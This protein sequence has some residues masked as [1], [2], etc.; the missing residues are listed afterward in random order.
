MKKNLV[1]SIA[2]FTSFIIF[3]ILV[4]NV[5]LKPIGPN[6]SVVGF[7]TLN[8]WFNNLAN[9]NFVIYNIT[10]WLSLIPIGIGIFYG[11][12]GLIQLIKRR[13]LLKVDTN[14]LALGIFY[15]L[16]LAVYLFFEFVVINRRP[17]LIDGYLESSYPSSTTIL[18]LCFMGTLIIENNIY[19]KKTPKIVLNTITTLFIVFM[20]IGRLIS[21]VHWI[22]DIM[23]GVI[24]SFSLNYL[25]LFLYQFLNK[26]N[27]I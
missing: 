17:V 21:R 20:V 6:N 4:M 7:S 23:A 2:L 10:D 8:G 5:D 18:V 26:K 22:T 16:T 13:S 3:T 15:I 24:I 27:K 25:Y 14:I 9:A 1:I 11:I 19:L 12:I